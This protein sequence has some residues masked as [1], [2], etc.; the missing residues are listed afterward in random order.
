M[1]D[2]KGRLRKI[3]NDFATTDYASKLEENVKRSRKMQ[4][5]KDTLSREF[6][7]LNLQADVRAKLDIKR[8]EVN[9]K[10]KD[11]KNMCVV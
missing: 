9:T 7:S 3:Q 8:D 5:Q 10:S 11:I 2:T 4:D 1:E 6:R